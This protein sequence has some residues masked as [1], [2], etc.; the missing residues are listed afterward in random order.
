MPTKIQLM[1]EMNDTKT[2]LF[3][4]YDT[5][6]PQGCPCNDP[7][8]WHSKSVFICTKDDN[9]NEISRC[10]LYVASARR[11]HFERTI[12]DKSV[13]LE[14]LLEEYKTRGKMTDEL[15][16]A[17]VSRGFGTIDEE[18]GFSYKDAVIDKTPICKDGLEIVEKIKDNISEGEY[19][20]LCNIFKKLHNHA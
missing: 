12:S 2:K 6:R 20:E 1:K 3:D 15:M 4:F 5:C 19:L 16:D 14:E 8:C 11:E 13:I 7:K 9:L 17:A 10:A 18:E